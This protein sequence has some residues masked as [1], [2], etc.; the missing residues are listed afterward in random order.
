M[1]LQENSQC[2]KILDRLQAQGGEGWVA[3]PELVAVSG[4]FNIHSR[5]DELRSKHGVAI[6]NLTDLST[7]PHVSLYRLVRP[8]TPERGSVSRSTPATTVNV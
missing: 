8:A 4:S 1:R 3:M 5:V 6:E 2:K 7:K